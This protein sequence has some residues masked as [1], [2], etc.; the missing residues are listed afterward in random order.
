MVRRY[1][2]AK[3]CVWWNGSLHILAGTYWATPLNVF[4]EIRDLSVL[5]GEQHGE[6]SFRKFIL[7]SNFRLSVETSNVDM[8]RKKMIRILN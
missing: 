3:K 4:L 1:V 2:E 6:V 8:S 5:A 7:V